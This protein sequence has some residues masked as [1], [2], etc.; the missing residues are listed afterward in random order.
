[1]AFVVRRFDD[2]IRHRRVGIVDYRKNVFIQRHSIGFGLSRLSPLANALPMA[3]SP[4]LECINKARHR[5]S[6]QAPTLDTTQPIPP[7]RIERAPTVRSIPAWDEAP[8]IT[9]EEK[10]KG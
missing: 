1:M 4:F 10:K 5:T 3:S 8:G 2:P 7:G 9:D 6:H